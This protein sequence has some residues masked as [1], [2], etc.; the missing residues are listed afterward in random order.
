[1]VAY[2]LHLLGKDRGFKLPQHLRVQIVALVL[3][4][5]IDPHLILATLRFREEL[6]ECRRMMLPSAVDM[7]DDDDADREDEDEYENERSLQGDD[8]WIIESVIHRYGLSAF[9]YFVLESNQEHEF[10]S[11][12]SDG[13]GAI[14]YAIFVEINDPQLSIVLSP[15]S[16]LFMVVPVVRRM[17]DTTDLHVSN[18][19]AREK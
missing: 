17:L 15:F 1:M 12:S 18:V 5:G 6:L 16:W 4:M 13:I 9:K 2:L 3:E 8:D 14:A 19:V 7:S 10:A 11:W